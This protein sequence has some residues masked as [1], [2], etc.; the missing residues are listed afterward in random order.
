V[1]PGDGPAD[2]EP[3]HHEPAPDDEPSHEGEPVPAGAG[4]PT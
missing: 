3:A 1:S 2:G 4:A